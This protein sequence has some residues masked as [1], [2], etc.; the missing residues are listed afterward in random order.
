MTIHLDRRQ[1]M[2][3]ALLLLIAAALFAAAYFFVLAPRY[4]QIDQLEDMIQS[5]KKVLAAMEQN[6]SAPAGD[7]GES[8][9]G[10][11]QKVP[12]RPLADQLLLEFQK[13]EYLSD[14]LLVNVSFSDGEKGA[15]GAA[16][17]GE[18]GEGGA[19]TPLA[20]PEGVQTITAQLTVES[21]SYY[22]LE[23]FLQ[24]LE[25]APR[26]ISIDSLTFAGP[27]ELTSTA[28]DVQPLSYSLTVSAFYAPQ[29]EKWKQFLPK[30]DVPPP[31]GKDNPLTEMAP[32]I[33]P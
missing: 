14:S 33:G 27:P 9:A 30:K 13:A 28:T 31:S 26:I 8:L 12:V 16:Q 4:Q 7:V 25:N 3:V 19:E 22:Q 2:A 10:L 29:F 17:E 1:L 32:P 20:P 11:Q 6:V 15:A 5:E 23:R 21:P 18:A 24:V